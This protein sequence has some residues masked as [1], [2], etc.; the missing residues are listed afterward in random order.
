MCVDNGTKFLPNDAVVVVNNIEDFCHETSLSK[1]KGRK[2]HGLRPSTCNIKPSTH[3]PEQLHQLLHVD[4]TVEAFDIAFAEF[5][6]FTV[7][8]T[9]A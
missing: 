2:P 8:V 5:G 7:R 4:Y 1:V 9:K 6:F 3:L